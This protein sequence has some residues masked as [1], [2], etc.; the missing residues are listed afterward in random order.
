ERA[1][2]RFGL[3]LWKE[4]ID[5]QAL[6]SIVRFKKL[7][8]DEAVLVEKASRDERA[9]I[10]LDFAR[11]PAAS[12]QR[13]CAEDILVQFADLRFTEPGNARRGNFALEVSVEPTNR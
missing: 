7:D 6:E 5:D 8:G 13:S 1:T 10:L 11:F 3:S 12:V 4:N 2:Y 9:Q